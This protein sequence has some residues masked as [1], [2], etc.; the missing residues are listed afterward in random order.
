MKDTGFSF[1]LMAQ[2]DVVLNLLNANP[3]QDL[4]SVNPNVYF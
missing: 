3:E 2:F 4:D 1:C